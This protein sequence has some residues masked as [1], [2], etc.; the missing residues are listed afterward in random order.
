MDKPTI[1]VKRKLLFFLSMIVAAS[2]GLGIRVAYIQIFK[3]EELQ[4]M[5]YEQQTRDRLIAPKRGSILDRNGVG[6]AVT[7]SVTAVSVIHAQI[8][9]EEGVA[10]FLAEKLDLNYE[11]VLEKVKKRVA[12]VRI[13]TKVDKDLALE[14]RKANLPGVVVDEDVKRIYPYSTLAAQVI[15]FVGKDNQGDAVIIRINTKESKKPDKS[16]VYDL[17]GF[18]IYFF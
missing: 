6:I 14:I 7:K 18:Y 17:S 2:I 16:V 3:A 9:D 8:K 12:L 4:E 5:A 10:R 15:G 1:G 11:N 13:K